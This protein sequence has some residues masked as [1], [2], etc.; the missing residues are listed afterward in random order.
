MSGIDI[1]FAIC[2]KTEYLTYGIYSV[3]FILSLVVLRWRR[4]NKRS[5]NLIHLLSMIAIFILTT[6]CVILHSVVIVH[7]VLRDELDPVTYPYHSQAIQNYTA[8]VIALPILISYISDVL[9]I[10]RMYVIWGKRKWIVMIPFI[11]TTCNNAFA[12]IGIIITEIEL[13]KPGF[14]EF[15]NKLSDTVFSLNL[16]INIAVIALNAAKIHMLIKQAHMILGADVKKFYHNVLAIIIESGA[17]YVLGMFAFLITTLVYPNPP[18][19][20]LPAFLPVLSATPTLIIVRAGLGITIENVQE[21]MITIT[22]QENHDRETQLENLR[23]S[24]AV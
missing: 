18:T 10:Y 9:I 6:L 20:Y 24:S 11:L 23:P 22:Q 19:T 1:H 5:N 16:L 8:G 17:L 4:A 14:P 3:L 12:M 15:K 7:I 2:S 21:A 13:H